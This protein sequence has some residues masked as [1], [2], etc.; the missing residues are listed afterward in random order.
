[1]RWL[2]L[3]TSGNI[4]QDIQLSDFIDM[5]ICQRFRNDDDRRHAQSCSYPFWEIIERDNYYN[6]SE[7]FI[8]A[9]GA[10]IARNDLIQYVNGGNLLPLQ[11]NFTFMETAFRC[12]SNNIPL[13]LIG[14]TNSGK[15][16]LVRYLA[17]SVGANLMSFP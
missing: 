4:S 17:N 12:I 5:I 13:I 1:M 15:T 14:P 16:D 10:L 9:G 11:C 3:Y 2:S 6:C 8:Q 7:S